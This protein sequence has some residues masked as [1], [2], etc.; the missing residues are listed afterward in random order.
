[1][2]FADQ[3]FTFKEYHTDKDN[4]DYIS[5]KGLNNSLKFLRILMH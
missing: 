5:E 1:M 3:D 4:L 2:D